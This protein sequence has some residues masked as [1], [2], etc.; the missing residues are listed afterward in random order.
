MPSDFNIL[1]ISGTVF[2][3]AILVVLC[4]ILCVICFLRTGRIRKETKNTLT[5]DKLLEY[6]DKIRDKTAFS[7]EASNPHAFCKSAVVNF[8]AFEDVTGEYS[9]SL[10]LL[11]SFNNGYIITVL[12]GRESCNTYLRTIKSGACETFLLDEEKQV[13]ENVLNGKE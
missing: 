6:I 8:N 13:L 5:E 1:L 4:F 3:T 2:I 10:A 11:D 12:Y 9:F 7:G